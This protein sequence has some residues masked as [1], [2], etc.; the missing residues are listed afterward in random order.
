MPGVGY[1]HQESIF[2]YSTAAI[3]KS[4]SSSML[5]LFCEEPHRGKELKVK[6]YNLRL[7]PWEGVPSIMHDAVK[8]IAF[9]ERVHFP[10]LHLQK[11][12]LLT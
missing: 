10:R 7:Q 4:G 8:I 3:F 2:L 9:S 5:N 6:R 11:I 1:Q 12:V